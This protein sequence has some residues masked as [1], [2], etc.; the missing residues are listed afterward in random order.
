[1]CRYL[2]V[3][4]EHGKQNSM[5]R[6]TSVSEMPSRK[7]NRCWVLSWVGKLVYNRK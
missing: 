7:W 4:V 3:K 5:A 6:P 1:M 2:I